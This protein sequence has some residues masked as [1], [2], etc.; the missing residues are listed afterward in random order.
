[1]SCRRVT[2]FGGTGFLGRRIVRHLQNAD[3]AVRVASR[4]PDR[5]RSLSSRDISGIEPF[6]ADVNDDRSVASAVSNAWAVV[7]AVSLYVEHGQCTFQSVHVE[8][9]RRVAMLAR[10][11]GVETLI[12]ISGIGANAGS[13]SPYIRSRGEGE[14]AVLDA[15]PSAKLIRPAVMFGPGDAFLTPLLTMLQ[16]LPV[17]PMF[18]SGETRLQ[19]AYVE[20]VAEAIVRVLRAPAVRQLYE[21]AGPRVYTYQELLRTIAASTGTRPLLVRFPFSIWPRYAS[22]A[23]SFATAA[24]IAGYL[25]VQSEPGACQQADRAPVQP[26]MHPVTVEFD[27]VQPI[28]PIRRLVDQLGELRFDP[29][30]KRCRLGATPSSKRSRHVLRHGAP[31]TADRS[32]PVLPVDLLHD[33]RPPVHDRQHLLGLLGREHRR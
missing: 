7:N 3:F 1:M 32:G 15:F 31:V 17:F 6:R 8:A 33:F 13:T 5:G 30:R 4:H 29:T 19:P 26:G 28:R 21:L 25:G 10:R 23:G 11:A 2:V 9:A 24:A 16:H 22:R 18:G 14:A 27:F 20:D 12:H